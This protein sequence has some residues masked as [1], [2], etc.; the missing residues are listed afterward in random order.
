M[1]FGLIFP[2]TEKWLTSMEGGEG[3]YFEDLKTSL[4][5]GRLAI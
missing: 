3:S 1:R 2:L 5:L 4:N